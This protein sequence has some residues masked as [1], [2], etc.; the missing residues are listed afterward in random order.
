MRNRGK[1]QLRIDEA[2]KLVKLCLKLAD[3]NHAGAIGTLTALM[4]GLRA[5]EVT[6][7]VVR[8]L[9]DGGRLLWVPYGK[10]Q[11]SKR[12]LEVP[13]MLRPYLL[14]LAEGRRPDE[15][16]LGAG[17]TW[18]A[19]KAKKRDRRWL[20]DQV[21]IIC[22]KAGVPPVCTHS[23]RGLHATLATEAGATPQLVANALGHTSPQVAQLHYT[24]KA[25]THRANTRKVVDRLGPEEDVEQGSP[26]G[27]LHPDGSL[28]PLGNN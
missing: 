27:R 2:R 23:L 1:P 18:H 15:Q 26:S 7:R 21:Q 24:D 13:A 14:R 19:S 4:L 17:H 5:S 10:T 28:E 8:D 22:T 20:F 11:R 3:E 9:D 6:D 12:T 25:A 16:L